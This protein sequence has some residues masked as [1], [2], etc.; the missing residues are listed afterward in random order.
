[1][2]EPVDQAAVVILDL[3]G[4]ICI[5]LGN[6]SNGL[7]DAALACCDAVGYIPQLGRVG[8]LNV[9]AVSLS[10]MTSPVTRLSDRVT[11]AVRVAS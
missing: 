8:S 6:E 5:A 1:V 11:V 7:N 9:A 10:V 4:D 2:V 3:K